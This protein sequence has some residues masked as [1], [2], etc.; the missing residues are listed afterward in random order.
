MSIASHPSSHAA[1]QLVELR[2]RRCEGGKK[3]QRGERAVLTTPRG[4]AQIAYR[5]TFAFSSSQPTRC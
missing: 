3:P 5:A 4:R 2:I 1:R